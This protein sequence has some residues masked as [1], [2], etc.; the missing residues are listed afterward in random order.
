MGKTF[1]ER[2]AAGLQP[3]EFKVRKL[4]VNLGNAYVR[5]VARDRR[6]VMRLLEQFAFGKASTYW[7]R[8]SADDMQACH[9]QLQSISPKMAKDFRRW[10]S[11]LL[12]AGDNT[13]LAL[14][15]LI[16]ELVCRIWIEEA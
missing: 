4:I 13:T 9:L 7:D 3:D 1:N 10:S 16:D 8:W 14:N 5:L 15:C 11:E 12:K 6:K 2:P